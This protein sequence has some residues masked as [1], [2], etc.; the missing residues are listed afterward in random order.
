MEHIEGYSLLKLLQEAPGNMLPEEHAKQYIRQILEALKFLHSLG[1]KHGDITPDNIILNTLTDQ[2]K[3][4]DFGYADITSPGKT[5]FDTVLGSP[6][7]MAPEI[8]SGKYDT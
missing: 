7:Y 4:A 3:L 8:H 6:M 2:I 1:I 5:H